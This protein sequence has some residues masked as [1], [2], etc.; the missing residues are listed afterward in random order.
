MKCAAEWKSQN[1]Q[2][3]WIAIESIY[4]TLVK[5]PNEALIMRESQR[6]EVL[7]E[8]YLQAYTFFTPQ[9]EL[10]LSSSLCASAL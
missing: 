4:S 9:V 1:S 3:S 6:E 7:L 8:Q 2:A 10:T 5:T